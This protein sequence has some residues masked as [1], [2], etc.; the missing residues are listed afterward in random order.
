MKDSGAPVLLD[1]VIYALHVAGMPIGAN[2]EDWE[3]NADYRLVGILMGLL[4]CSLCLL[5][6]TGIAPGPL[7]WSIEE[8]LGNWLIFVLL[9]GAAI[10]ILEKA[11]R[12]LI[13]SRG[14]V[15]GVLT[16]MASHGRPRPSAWSAVCLMGL[17]WLAAVTLV[18]VDAHVSG[19]LS[20]W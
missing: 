15:R 6:I 16:R 14:G 13:D 9:A 3:G 4:L 1:R 12:A 20:I 11:S 18:V 2:P 8:S 10:W 17:P 5:S 19:F 7:H